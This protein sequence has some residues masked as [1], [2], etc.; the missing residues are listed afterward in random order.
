MAL[1]GFTRILGITLLLLVICLV[2][3]INNPVFVGAY[4]LSNLLRWTALFGILGLGVAFVIITGGI[5]L[6][7]GAV[8]AL[9]GIVMM[10]LLQ[11]PKMSPTVA[12]VITLGVGVLIGIFHGILIG[13]CKLQSFIVTLCGLM[14]Y[15]GLAQLISGDT[16]LSLDPA[17]SGLREFA[18]GSAFDLP[19]PFIGAIYTPP[20]AEGSSLVT[21]VPLPIPML[22]LLVLAVLGAVFLHKTVPG[23]YLMA[24]GRNEEAARFS[25]INTRRMTLLAYVLCSTLAALGGIL[26]ALDVNTVQPS[27]HGNFYELYAI[28]AAVLGGCSLRGGVGSIAGVVIGTAVMRSLYNAI[29]LLEYPT[30]WEYIIIGSVLLIGVMIDEIGRQVVSRIK[31][32]RRKKML[33]G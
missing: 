7:I 15:R 11:D 13:Y 29:N 31:T 25:G 10:D 23:R 6:S 16:T 19:V 21:W 9:T 17:F 4:N 24:M 12:I 2:T 30:Y 20:N 8:V 1:H 22:I 14:G 32:Q 28:A 18:T 3:T 26:F 33:S 27:S 5:D